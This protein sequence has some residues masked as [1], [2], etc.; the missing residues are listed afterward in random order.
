VCY[1]NR[2]SPHRDQEPGC[3]G[4]SPATVDGSSTRRPTDP[5]NNARNRRHRPTR[6]S[7]TIRT[8]ERHHKHTPR[9]SSNEATPAD[10][11]LALWNIVEI[12]REGRFE[13][14]RV[15]AGAYIRKFQQGFRRDESVVDLSRDA[16]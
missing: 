12:R 5:K 7:E 3:R 2:E 14:A 15:A 13:E 6:R 10:E 16:L 1:G 9:V 4:S 11:D 8:H